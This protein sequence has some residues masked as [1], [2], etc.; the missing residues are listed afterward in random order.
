MDIPTLWILSF[1]TDAMWRLI[2]KNFYQ[3]TES[4]ISEVK[5]AMVSWQTEAHRLG[6]PQRDI[7]S[8][9]PR[10]NKWL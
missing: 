3:K 10:I 4:I 2:L 5:D 1:S 8:F 6:I 9:A 7:V